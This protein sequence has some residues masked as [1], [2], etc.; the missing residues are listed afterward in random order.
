MPR[1]VKMKKTK[2][3]RVVESAMQQATVNKQQHKQQ[4][5]PS[6]EHVARARRVKLET[7]GTHMLNERQ[8]RVGLMI[9]WPLLFW[10]YF[11]PIIYSGNVTTN[12]ASYTS[13]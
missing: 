1:L 11:H 9:L 10:N 6:T 7:D 2:K 12:C 5:T 4:S 13:E 8:Q 3:Q